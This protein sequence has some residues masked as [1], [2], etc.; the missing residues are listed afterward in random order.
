MNN[1]LGVYP[2]KGYQVDLGTPVGAPTAE[3][4]A[5]STQHFTLAGMAI[6]N[7]GSCQVSLS[8]DKGKTF[9]VLKSWIGNCPVTTASTS[10]DF[11]LP[12]D[13]PPGE[14]IFAWTW[15][16][17]IG[18]RE[19][20]MNCAAVTIQPGS[21]P[22]PSFASRPELFVANVKNGCTT[23]EN[24]DV[25]FPNP[26]PVVV[27]S[28]KNPLAPVGAN[29]G[30]AVAGGAAPPV[31]KPSSAGGASASASPSAGAGG[32]P[33]PQPVPTTA[34]YDDGSW[35]PTKYDKPPPKGRIMY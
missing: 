27:N 11:A 13:T 6:H 32:H 5:G 23:V 35:S 19:M 30:K 7:G 8:Y 12:G 9:K 34:K 33:T 25:L 24:G 28:S 29:C 22:G 16:N 31:Q 1:P 10:L 2:C 18:N 26:G 4:P 14:A 20:Y 21:G 3:W 15:F 17:N